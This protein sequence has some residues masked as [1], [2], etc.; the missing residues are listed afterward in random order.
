MAREDQKT[1][2]VLLVP[3][4]SLGPRCPRV[5]MQPT[6]YLER[7]RLAL[8]RLKTFTHEG[9]DDDHREEPQHREGT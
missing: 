1:R 7:E 3:F 4:T 2:R 9:G 6:S 5:P 8:A